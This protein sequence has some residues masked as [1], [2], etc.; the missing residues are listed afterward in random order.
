MQVTS[1]ARLLKPV[2]ESIRHDGAPFVKL[3]PTKGMKNASIIYQAIRQMPDGTL[4]RGDFD[5]KSR[6]MVYFPDRP[7]KRI[8]VKS[9]IKAKNID[10]DRR[11]LSSFLSSIVEAAYTA[12]KP[13]TKLIKAAMELKFKI[14][15]VSEN[16]DD[17]TAGDIR[18]SLHTIAMAYTREKLEQITSPHRLLA[19]QDSGIQR[20]RFREFIQINRKM[21]GQLS[22][23][24][25]PD[26]GSKYDTTPELA[27]YEMK[28]LLRSYRTRRLTDTI[29]FL[30]FLRVKGISSNIYFFAKRWQA[31]SSPTKTENRIQLDT[32]PWAK[33]MD[34]ICPIIEKLYRRSARII[35]DE[36]R[37]W[38]T[39]EWLVYSNPTPE[40]VP[41]LPK[42]PPNVPPANELGPMSPKQI[43]P[44]ADVTAPV[45]LTL[46]GPPDRKLVVAK[47]ETNPLYLHEGFQSIVGETSDDLNTL[48][49][50]RTNGSL[51]DLLLHSLV[52]RALFR[53]A[54]PIPPLSTLPLDAMLNDIPYSSIAPLDN[55]PRF[56]HEPS[57][58][59]AEKA[60]QT[61]SETSTATV[62]PGTTSRQ[63]PASQ[64]PSLMMVFPK[65][66]YSTLHYST[67][68]EDPSVNG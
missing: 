11:E 20:K 62:L 59:L 68:E 43:V 53:V 25:R 12:A 28:Q 10:D 32:E 35:G 34:K 48:S 21:F 47:R 63:G 30:E 60:E 13:H 67:T 7:P 8:E 52:P 40:N 5:K 56:I 37:G 24:L 66:G 16:G 42:T 64:A 36:S 57:S 17:F 23:A 26:S 49:P 46:G 19:K 61:V 33:E 18:K 38:C 3:S 45:Q 4:I 39:Q 27:V 31:I 9:P 1:D 15:D 54:N 65:I 51:S 55:S 50:A 2:T 41:P 58:P 6:P 14:N 22:D 44:N 29:S